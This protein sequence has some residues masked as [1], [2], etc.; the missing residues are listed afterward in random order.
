MWILFL[1]WLYARLDSNFLTEFVQSNAHGIVIKVKC[2]E[3]VL[4]TCKNFEYILISIFWNI[5]IDTDL[6]IKIIFI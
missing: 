4:D 1:L 3:N 5:N 6:F 2:T